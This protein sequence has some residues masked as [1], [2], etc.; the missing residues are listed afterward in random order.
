VDDLRHKGEHL[1]SGEVA[2][3]LYAT[4][5]LP[6]EI[7]RDLVHGQGFLIDEAGY[8]QAR[9]AH[10]LASG[11]GAFGKYETDSTVY[12]DLLVEAIDQGKLESFVDYDPYYGSQMSSEIIGII[13]D[14]H[15]VDTIQAG[16]QAELVTAET[17]FYVEAGGDVS[18]MGHILL[19]GSSAEFV[20]EGMHQ[21][22]A[23]LVVHAGRLVSG[24][25]NVGQ[26]V[27]LKVDNSRRSDIRRNHT[28]TH[29]LHKELRSH[30]GKH[31]AQAGSLVAP[32]R[33]R[34][35]FS[36]GEAV[37]NETLA[38]IESEINRTILANYPVRVDYMDQKEAIGRGAMALF[39]EKYG[40]I[41][42]TISVGTESGEEAYSFE[43]CGGL[44]VSETNDL[45]LFRFT[46][47]EAVAAGVRRVEAVTGRAA[48]S[49]IA[50]RLDTLDRVAQLLNS[51][52]QDV[53]ARLESLLADS[54]IMQ[55]EMSQLQRQSARIQFAGLLSQIEQV[56]GVNVL[57]AQ[58][59]VSSVDNLREMADWYRDKVG[60]G[61]AVIGTV[62]NGKPLLIATVT[63]DLIKRGV[64]AGDLVRDVAKIVGGG[65]GG[66]PN[67][68]Q[69]GGRDP[70]KIPEAL[71]AV[72]A[73]VKAALDE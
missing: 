24:E 38:E 19:P 48:Q 63:E 68:A 7:T 35:D 16:Q 45:G 51:P 64:K 73:L 30:L 21:P 43:L 3:N 31:V 32:D 4:Y 22:V 41:V 10:A 6:V 5:G 1:I 40:D 71:A 54:K 26:E 44:H 28:A 66:R 23:G 72:P 61:T 58:V 34:F 67:M 13:Q 14:G 2:F 25:M 49:L 18:D 27:T 53:E 47:E 39:G 57:A 59:D 37:D 20:V 46:G 52:I 55:K 8:T 60:S 17:P 29:L 9:T 69:A 11:S 70:E 15:S 36:H 33:L 42:R 62:I 50:G 12:G 65:G 56:D